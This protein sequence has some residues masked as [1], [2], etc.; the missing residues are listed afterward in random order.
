[1]RNLNELLT[2]RADELTDII[3]RCRRAL[4]HAPT[5]ALRAVMIKGKPRYYH[6]TSKKDRSGKYLGADKIGLARRLAQRDYLRQVL[7]MSDKLLQ[8]VNGLL[9]VLAAYSPE[10]YYDSLNTARKA[11]VTPILLSDEAFAKYW[12]S[13]PYE[14][15]AFD[16]GAPEYYSRKGERMRSKSEVII[17]DILYSLGIPYKYECPLILDNG[18]VIYPDF[19]ILKVST[20]EVFIL[21]H[22]GMMGDSYYASHNIQRLNDLIFSGFI[23]GINLI[24]TMESDTHPLNTKAIETML[25]KILI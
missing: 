25:Q 1:M 16:I 18:K 23:P 9:S 19:T 17:A 20:R 11:L 14:S 22:M 3:S 15:K 5:G 10:D 24:L 21:E 6:R 8:S 7:E 13:Q 2:K 12:E 4:A